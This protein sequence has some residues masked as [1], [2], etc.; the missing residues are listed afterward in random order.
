[1]SEL[2]V[3]RAQAEA[4]KATMR[5]DLSDTACAIESVGELLFRDSISLDHELKDRDKEGLVLAISA[6]GRHVNN[7]GE[8]IIE[9]LCTAQGLAEKLEKAAGS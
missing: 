4:M 7:L 1:M 2:S 3:I 6:L 9:E 5:D 8:G